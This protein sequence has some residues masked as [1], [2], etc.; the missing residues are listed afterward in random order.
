M[1]QICAVLLAKKFLCDTNENLALEMFQPSV[2]NDFPLPCIRILI[3][4]QVTE[5]TA[6]SVG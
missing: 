6:Y 4:M 5:L 1:E 2:S 3:V